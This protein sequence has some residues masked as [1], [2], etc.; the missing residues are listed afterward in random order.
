MKLDPSF[1]GR[2]DGRVYSFTRGVVKSLPI[3][4][5]ERR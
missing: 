4:P 5:W 3:L 1:D 2:V